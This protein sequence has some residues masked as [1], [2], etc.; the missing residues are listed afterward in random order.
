MVYVL[1]AS[2]SLP[3][4]SRCPNFIERETLTV[5]HLI[6][7]SKSNLIVTY[8]HRVV[9]KVKVFLMLA[10]LATACSSHRWFNQ[11]TGATK[12]L[13]TIQGNRTS[14]PRY[15]CIAGRLSF[16]VKH[17]LPKRSHHGEVL[18]SPNLGGQSS[19][20]PNTTVLNTTASSN[21]TKASP[22]LPSWVP[23]LE[24]VITAVFRVAVLLF[25][26]DMTLSPADN[27]PAMTTWITLSSSLHST[28]PPRCSTLE[29]V[30]LRL[31]LAL[32]APSTERFTL[33]RH[34]LGFQTS[35]D[36]LR[37]TTH[38]PPPRP[39]TLHSSSVSTPAARGTICYQFII[40]LFGTRALDCSRARHI[41]VIQVPIHT[42]NER[43][44]YEY[45]VR[46]YRYSIG[47][48]RSRICIFRCQ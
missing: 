34:G 4:P 46:M 28:A 26:I 6:F 33:E 22:N 40:I 18:V 44:M 24:D 30:K 17:T 5:I 42:L 9:M 19:S 16:R 23:T 7:P 32:T 39:F 35:V 21:G 37:R 20:Q 25:N 2:G 36:S 10:M 27:R 13:Q 3:W 47:A 11:P 43:V 41:S 8:I 15:V 14:D 29:T 12:Q 45:G 31:D 1:L 38:N 48:W